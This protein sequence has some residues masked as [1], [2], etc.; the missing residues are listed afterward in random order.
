MNLLI[1]VHSLSSGGAERVTA[2]L[3]NHWVGKGW[4]VTVVTIADTSLDF[5]QLH[6]AVRRIYLNLAEESSNALAA[7]CNNLKRIHALRNVLKEVRPQV[8]LGMMTTASVL[9]AFA[10]R[11]LPCL[12]TIGAERNHPPQLPVGPFW[13]R[14]R[15]IAYGWLDALTVQAEESRSWFLQHSKARHIVVIPN[16]VQLPLPVQQ[17][18]LAPQEV[19][20]GGS[21]TILAVGRLEVQKGFDLLID[22]FAQLTPQHPDWDLVILGEGR[23]RAALESQIARLALVDRVRLPGRVGNVSTWY[24]LVD[25][26]VMSSRFEGFPNTLI[27]AMAHG[28]PVVSFDCDTGPRDIIRHE[29]DGLLVLNGDVSALKVA[30]NR[31][32]VNEVLRKQF[33][34]NSLQIT[35]RFSTEKVLSLWENLFAE[36]RR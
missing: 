10:G 33:G 31:L 9:L 36:I 2:N 6:P 13:E 32:M 20:R 8:A 25:I 4:Q 21:R 7:V 17:P 19:L 24:S 11:G 14:L 34:V 30:L 16:A 12:A 28:L 3:A 5:Y 27:E 22:A 15:S 26:Y 18:L 23:Q 1:F 35:N 29:Q